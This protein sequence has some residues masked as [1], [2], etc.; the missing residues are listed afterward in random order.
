M[1]HFIPT[2]KDISAEETA[3]IIIREVVR[4]HGIPK[5]IITDRG[6]QFVSR[7]WSHLFK[8]LGTKVKLS[9]AYHPQT[10]GQTERVNQTLEQYLRCSINH[11]QDNWVELL[12]LAEFAYNNA[13]HSSTGKSPFYV[14]YGC[15]PI[16]EISRPDTSTNPAAENTLIRIERTNMELKH[17]LE[18]AQENYKRFADRKRLEG[19][20]FNIGDKVWL[21]RKN[22]R[23]ARPSEKLDFRRIG[24]YKVLERINDV[25]YRLELTPSMKIHD[26]FHVSLLEKYHQNTLTGRTQPRLPPIKIDGKEEFVVNDILDS[27]LVWK[28]LQYLV[29]WKGYGVE[30]R[31]WEPVKHVKNAKEKV[32]SFHLKYPEKPGAET[33]GLVGM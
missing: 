30:E 15:H 5:D 3:I 7:F 8:G 4:L 16:F 33:V 14:N 26:V 27:R 21:I 18:K 17:Q 31:T 32:E 29:D 22:I 13:Q 1:S 6:P 28:T 12:P 20:K 11:L 24:P 2:K 19:P 23:T 9:S 10:D 25:A